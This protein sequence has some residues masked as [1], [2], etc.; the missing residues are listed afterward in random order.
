[1]KNIIGLIAI[2]GLVCGFIY[3]CILLSHVTPNSQDIA[4]LQADNERLKID[5]RNLSTELQLV[6]RKQNNFRTY[7]ESDKVKRLSEI[8]ELDSRIKFLSNDIL[9]AKINFDDTS[10]EKCE[11]LISELWTELEHIRKMVK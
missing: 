8:K 6:N 11:V 5:I 4:L 10:H 7:Y 3:I 9:Q 2:F 1:M